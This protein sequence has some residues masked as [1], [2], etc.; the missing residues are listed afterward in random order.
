[1]DD[2]AGHLGAALSGRYRLERELGRGGMAT[3]YL[4][5]DLRHHRRVALKVLHPELASAII[6]DR[7][8]REV[9]T[10]AGLTHPHIVPL[11]DSGA[12]PAEPGWDR[13]MWYSMPYV[14]GESLRQRLERKGR[15]PV[16]EAVRIAGEVADALDHAHTHGVIHRDIKPENIL[17]AG[18]HALVADFGVARA[19]NAAGEDRLT[20]TGI[21]LGTPMY[22]S[23]EQAAGARDLD[24]RSDIY[25]LGCV[26]FEMLAGRPPW[27]GPTP[28]TALARRFSEPAPSVRAARE[29]IPFSIERAV[30]TA[31]AADPARRFATAGAFAAALSPAGLAGGTRPQTWLVRG[32]LA[33]A[34]L[35]AMVLGARLLLSRHPS[36]ARARAGSHSLAVMPFVSP[37]RDSANAYFGAG[38]AE[39]LTT[40]F[41]RV[42]GL[43]VASRG[44]ASR[45]Q[46]A[47]A[48]DVEVARQLGVRTI[49]EGTVRRSGDRIRVTARLVDPS[50]GTILWAEQYDRRMAEV[51]EMQDDMAQAIVAALVPTLAGST[52]PAARAVRGTGDLEA[53][54]LFLKGR[55]YWA[56]RGE[57]GLRASIGYFERALALDPGFARAWAGLSMAQVVLPFF[58]NLP[59]D[60][61]LALAA[62]NAQRALAIDSTVADAHLAW[63]Y[64]LKG[65]WRWQESEREFRRALA[66][67]PDDAPTHHWYAVL[68]WSVGRIDAAVEQLTTARRLDPLG[69]QIWTDYAYVLYLAR[70]YPEALAEAQRVW[71]M[72]TLKSDGAMEIGM[73][74]LA[75]G[76]PDSALEAFRRAKRI[77]IGFDDRAFLSVAA[78]R[79]GRTREADSLYRALLREEAR[80]PSVAYAVAIAAA[81]AG[82]LDRG[83]RAVARA[84]DQRSIYFSEISLPCDALLDPLKREPGFGQ[85][86]SRAGMR[87]CP[88]DAEAAR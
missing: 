42:P 14:E 4:A 59:A 58:S 28:Q 13:L 85:L 16:G 62:Q 31:L 2:L 73:M 30:E 83:V 88:P 65:Q 53:Y 64:A 52:R 41:A 9:E 40:A 34:A 48:G 24:A 18:S 86:L 25:S 67:A 79:T 26:L 21:S 81:G 80:D 10:A 15:L 17:L 39:E 38:I 87:V 54:Q 36:A 68:L 78:R 35:V 8:L 7:F 3:V 33:L 43:R 61:L 60:S 50:D 49:L 70:R 12:I 82:D 46:D 22:M 23:P 47:G 19:L 29:G 11:F 27:T 71:P 66:L 72:D 74:R 1:V 5:E 63:A 20:A 76:Q 37:D 77:G 6:L 51:F 32:A 56:R 84:V 69:V 45:F 44:S 57:N 55:Y 75:L